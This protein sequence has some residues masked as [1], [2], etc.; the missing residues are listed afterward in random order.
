MKNIYTFPAIFLKEENGY[1]V[2]FPDIE[3]AFTCGETFEEALL[4]AKDCL[5]LSLDDIEEIPKVSNIEDIALEKNEYIAII[6][7]DMLAFKRKYN[8]QTI[9]KTL[10]IPK[11]LNDIAL[12][13][14]IN[15][16]KVLQ[17]VLKEKLNIF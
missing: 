6:Q 9:K 8:N 17:Q 7:G 16:S 3:G 11:W 2:R 1:S 13:K 4:M 12:E 5:E 15:F 14:K 10:T